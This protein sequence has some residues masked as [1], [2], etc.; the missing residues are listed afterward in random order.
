MKGDVAW[1]TH[2]LETEGPP[3]LP[4]IV[5]LD[6]AG[7]QFSK[8]LFRKEHAEGTLFSSWGYPDSNMEYKHQFQ[9]WQTQELAN[10]LNEQTNSRGAGCPAEITWG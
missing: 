2:F 7:R 5:L 10:P 1:R 8:P 4:V 9:Y 6:E 3:R